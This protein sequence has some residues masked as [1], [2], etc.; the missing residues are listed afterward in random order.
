VIRF[1]DHSGDGVLDVNEVD[2]A[3]RKV[4]EYGTE[5]NRMG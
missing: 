5:W 3:L 1:L 4:M 2:L